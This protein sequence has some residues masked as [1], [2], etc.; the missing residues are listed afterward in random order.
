MS[1]HRTHNQQI[2]RGII[3]CQAETKTGL[4]GPRIKSTKTDSNLCKSNDN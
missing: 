2:D 3:N 4:P 1:N